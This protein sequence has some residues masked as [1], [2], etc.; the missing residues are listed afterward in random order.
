MRR[1]LLLSAVILGVAIGRAAR[2]DEDDDKQPS[3]T[4]VGHGEVQVVP[5]QVAVTLGVTTEGKTAAEAVSANTER[6]KALLETLRKHN[7]ADKHVQTSNF[8]VNP[9]QSFDREGRQPPKIVGYMVTNQ[10]TVRVLEV[11]RV[12]AILDA[13]VQAGSNQVQGIN[14]SVANPGP[15]LDQARR[16]AVDDAKHRAA[17]YAEAAGVKLGSP[18]HIEEQQSS[19]PRPMYA[20]AMREMAAADVP[21]AAGEQAISAEVVITYGIAK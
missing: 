16:K 9:Q 1:M 11:D 13:V 6:M 3:I 17:L 15:H 12:G 4:V 20:Q 10:V 18:L 19:G 7:V 14:F 2:A 21:V 5:D 8:H